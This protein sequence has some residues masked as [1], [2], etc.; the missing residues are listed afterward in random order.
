MEAEPAAF[1]KIGS[2]ASVPRNKFP[3]S[4]KCM[5]VI[6]LEEAI[7]SLD[8]SYTNSISPIPPVPSIECRQIASSGCSAS[9]EA[10]STTRS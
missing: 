5:F 8:K 1:I 7:S 9:G 6:V 3:N 4:S 10:I 2:D